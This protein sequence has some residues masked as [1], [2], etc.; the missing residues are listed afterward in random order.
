M[1]SD[2]N[3]SVRNMPPKCVWKWCD[4]RV[5]L[6]SGWPRRSTKLYGDSYRGYLRLFVCCNGRDN[7]AWM[8]HYWIGDVIAS[9]NNGLPCQSANRTTMA[10]PPRVPSGI[11]YSTGHFSP[12]TDKGKSLLSSAVIKCC[13][14][15]K[16]LIIAWCACHAL[17]TV[18]F[19]TQSLSALHLLLS[20]VNWITASNKDGVKTLLRIYS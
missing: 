11:T 20:N 4:R 13:M 10:T 18:T 5:V 7:G 3:S 9:G 2:G 17:S 16:L 19:I 14:Q 15:S 8:V 6:T 1:H 12:I